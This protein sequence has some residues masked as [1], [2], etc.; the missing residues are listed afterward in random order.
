MTAGDA[1]NVACMLLDNPN[2]P[3][4]D[5]PDF[6]FGAGTLIVRDR[7]GR[8]LLV[9]GQKSGDVH[10]LDLADR[11]A[12]VWRTKVG[13]GGIQGGVHFGMAA[14]GQAVFV[15][16]SD[17]RD[18]HVEG[19]TY[20]AEARPGL[21]A[22]DV[23]DGRLLWS[24]PANDVCNGREFCEPGLSAAI[25]TVPGAVLAG[26]MDGRVRGYDS[27]TGRVIW[28]YDTTAEVTA[29]DGSRARGGSIGG[30][31]GPVAAEGMVFVAS[32]YGIYFHMPGNLLLAFAPG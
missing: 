18:E 8:D 27:A 1:W 31:A 20:D 17:M 12:L 28:D 26:H 29:V 19:K 9:A 23:N 22:L 16:I 24:Q 4:E 25:G 5:G 2:C 7:T 15:P 21:Y 3:H 6:D 30:G 13:R 14:E 32:G 11:G 10:A